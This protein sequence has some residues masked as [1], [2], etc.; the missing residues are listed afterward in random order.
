[1]PGPDVTGTESAI[2][3]D[4]TFRVCKDWE[5]EQKGVPSMLIRDHLLM[6]R[7]GIPNWPPVWTWTDGL[8][9]THPK[10]EVG[11]LK[12][13]T[14]SGIGPSDR[15]YLHIYY[16]GSVYIGCLLFDDRA[17]CGQLA[18]LLDSYCNRSIAEIGGLDLSHTF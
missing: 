11:I 13:V 10:G 7:R 1:M 4:L 8:E 17:F 18:K 15:C 14:L 6:S 9:N 5:P 12:A 3:P 2:C 16:Q